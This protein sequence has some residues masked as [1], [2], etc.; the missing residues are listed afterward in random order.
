MRR[1]IE[2]HLELRA[3]EFE[4]QGMT[5]EAARRAALDLPPLN[6]GDQDIT[7]I[8]VGMPA[9]DDNPGSIWYRAV[10]PGYLQLMQMRLVAGRFFTPEDRQGAVPVGIVNEEAARRLWPGV[11][12]IG[13]ILA[14]GADPTDPRVTVIGVEAFDPLTFAVAPLLLGG[15]ALLASWLPAQRAMR[16]DP[17][18]AIR[19]E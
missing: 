7:A 2:L 9:R 10:T 4:A 15:M 14:S 18:L 13:R 12:P 3:G 11:S 17:L 6:G 16:V 19:E 1:E 8:P 5:P